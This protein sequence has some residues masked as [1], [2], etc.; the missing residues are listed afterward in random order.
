LLFARRSERARDISAPDCIC[1]K[2]RLAALHRTIAQL[3]TNDSTST[4]L[5]TVLQAIVSD[6]PLGM[7]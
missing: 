1:A 2:L 5:A 4:A 3:H 7:G 6:E